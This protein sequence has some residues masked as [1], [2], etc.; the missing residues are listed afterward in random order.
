[1]DILAQLCDAIGLIGTP[2]YCAQQLRKAEA[3]GIKH[4]YLMT[5]ETYQFPHRELQ[6][7]RDTIFPALGRV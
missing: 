6:A 4:L 7:F 1:D 2:D 3:N 5:G